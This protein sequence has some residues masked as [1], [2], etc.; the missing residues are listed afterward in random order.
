MELDMRIKNSERAKEVKKSIEHGCESIKKENIDSIL[1]P[2]AYKNQLINQ[3]IAYIAKKI[4]T[5]SKNRREY[6]Y[7]EVAILFS[8]LDNTVEEEVYYGDYININFKNTNLF[9][10]VHSRGGQDLMI[11][12]NH[13]NNTPPSGADIV[14]LDSY[15]SLRAMI[16]VGNT[17][18]MHIVSKTAPTEESA[19]YY[20]S[21]KAIELKKKDIENGIKPLNTKAYRDIAA[22]DILDDAKRFGL[23][24]K[25]FNRGHVL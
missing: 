10:I 7:G 18:G 14:L 5:L 16:T 20:I 15:F 19:L 2:N 24:H 8:A 3:K 22:N 25:K 11:A 1:V 13:P 4:L 17:H 23:I 6:V 12:H 9:Q 21:R